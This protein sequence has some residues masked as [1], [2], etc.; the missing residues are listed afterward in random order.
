MDTKNIAQ[1]L[2]RNMVD[3]FQQESS[4]KATI[5]LICIL[6]VL[7]ISMVLYITNR[8]Q[9]NEQN[10]KNLADIYD[11]FPMVSSINPNE[12]NYQYLLRDYYIKTA[13]N[14][15]CGGNFKNDFV[16]PIF[17]PKRIWL[18]VLGTF[19]DLKPLNVLEVILT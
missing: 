10:C 13:H 16:C 14:C 1:K 2:S 19:T 8:R 3:I 18:N 6:I 7:I 11:S 15:C 4:I 5:F 17:L 9:L 12:E